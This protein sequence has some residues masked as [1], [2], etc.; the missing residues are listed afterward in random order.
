MNMSPTKPFP[1]YKWRWASFQP[2][3]GLNVPSVYLGV[4]R[5][6]ADHEGEAPSAPSV[7]ADLTRVKNETAT[8]INLART[9]DRN[10]KRNSG[11][12]WTALGLLEPEHGSLHITTFGQAVASGRITP[13]AF[14]A[15]VV[16]SLTLP[17]K[18]IESNTD[19]WDRAGLT[20][21]PLQLILAI[22]ED[23][24]LVHGSKSARL[25]PFELVKIVIP[26]AGAKAQDS[27]IY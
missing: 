18:R 21:K 25:T 8:T 11:Q 27:R 19:E 17:N 10:L 15:G 16:N 23:L 3:E 22:M 7:I 24:A 9:G 12:Y 2:S 14:A 5:V 1:N 4:L 26:L 13:S 6:Y 20:I